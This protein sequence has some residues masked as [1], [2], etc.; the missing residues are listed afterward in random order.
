MLLLFLL[1]VLNVKLII[2]LAAILFIFAANYKS[3]SLKNIRQQRL[4]YFY[5]AIIII[6]CVNFLLQVK[7]T[8]TAYFLAFSMSTVLWTSA[9]L[10]GF[11]I[12]IL[13]QKDR[14]RPDSSGGERL[15]RTVE[16]F[17]ILHIGAVFF[18]LLL[19]MLETGSLNPYTYKGMHQR[20]YISTGDYISGITFDSPVTTAVISCFA[21]LYFLYRQK[22]LLSLA[23]MASLLIIGSNLTN[24]FMILV[25]AFSFAFH[26]DKI[27]KSLIT[28][29][30]CMLLLFITKVSPQ[31]NEYVGRF[32]YKML[33]MTYD[34]PK[35]NE[36]PDF[37]KMQPDNL[38]TDEEKRKKTALLHID[39]VS[40]AKLDHSNLSKNKVA[41]HIYISK[42][43]STDSQTL[44]MASYHNDYKEPEAVT[45]KINRHT[46]FL[47][48][49]YS[50][51]AEQ[52]KS[53][54][55]WN[56]PGKWIAF[57]QLIRYLK[58]HPGKIML[59]TGP[60]NFS[61]RTAFKTSTLG[62]AGSYPRQY[63]YIHPAFRNN[64]LF[65]YVF[66][67]SQLQP[68]HAAENTP[69]STY[70]QLLGEYGIIG[71]LAF[72]LL[73]LGYFL[74][75][76]KSLTFGLPV[77]LLLLLAFCTE[78]WFEQLSI[79]ILAELLLLLDIRLSAENKN[80]AGEGEQL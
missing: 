27:Q 78:Y 7:Q 44:K 18:N 33:G 25:L 59:G 17:F 73:Y 80:R 34:L 48:Q 41:E 74:R 60:G 52:L 35:K 79:V 67:H 65:T 28:A 2:K 16:V 50:G 3:L 39:S 56:K 12:Y 14:I 47:Q 61:S 55:D 45:D 70:H 64:H 22:F 21:V 66:Y 31:N 32:A 76:R 5:I 58:E 23:S 20:Y 57:L 51:E 42:L 24:L 71:L 10:A 15:Q 46:S 19:I 38:L 75:F 4:I 63:R 49:E 9:A 1:L 40:A 68:K 77:L 36:S 11:F 62:I 69:D 53:H 43:K 37:I 26:T 13:L 29:Y 30:T 8:T 72:V 6:S 54:Y